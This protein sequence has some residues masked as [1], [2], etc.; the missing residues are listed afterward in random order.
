MNKPGL[1]G[2]SRLSAATKY[3]FKGLKA[4]WKYEEGFRLEIYLA[5]FFIPISFFITEELAVRLC[6]IGSCFLILITE[7]INS[8]IE[9]I[10]DRVSTEQHPLS[11]QA[12]DIGSSTVFLAVILFIIIW[13]TTLYNYFQAYL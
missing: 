9:A 12:K 13:G 10:V 2:L 5:L 8:A 3:S 7:L 11:G 4:A 1:T 6:L